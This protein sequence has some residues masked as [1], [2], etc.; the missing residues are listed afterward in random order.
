MFIKFCL[1]IYRQNLK[2]TMTCGGVLSLTRHI[3]S[4]LVET[5][6]LQR[7]LFESGINNEQH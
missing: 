1:S 7:T 3:G 2:T 4:V 6:I 5:H